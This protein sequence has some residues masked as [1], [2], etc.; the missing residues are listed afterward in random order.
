MCVCVCVCVCVY[1]CVRKRESE[2]KSHFFLRQGNEI[3]T[4]VTATIRCELNPNYDHYNIKM[5]K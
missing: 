3:E 2:R 5:I 1:V 4:Q